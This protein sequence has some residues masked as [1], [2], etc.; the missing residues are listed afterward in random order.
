[1]PDQFD[2]NADWSS[3]VKNDSEKEKH[4]S[5]RHCRSSPPKNSTVLTNS[6][7]AD[8]G[9]DADSLISSVVSEAPTFDCRRSFTDVTQQIDQFDDISDSDDENVILQRQRRNRLSTIL[10]KPNITSSCSK[11][12][13]EKTQNSFI[14]ATGMPDQFDDN[15]DWCSSEKNDLKNLDQSMN[16]NDFYMEIPNN[17]YLWSK[18]QNKSIKEKESKIAETEMKAFPDKFDHALYDSDS[19]VSVMKDQFDD[20]YSDDDN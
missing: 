16:E 9:D 13:R 6:L 5:H 17:F 20:N 15:A 18:N 19:D 12:Y 7:F 11:Q 10:E 8:N 3:C 4:V 2:D 1:M 14:E